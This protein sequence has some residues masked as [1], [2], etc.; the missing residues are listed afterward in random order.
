M[1]DF[2]PVEPICCNNGT[3]GNILT[4]LDDFDV[5]FADKIS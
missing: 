4:A 2:I 1:N 5:G 3:K